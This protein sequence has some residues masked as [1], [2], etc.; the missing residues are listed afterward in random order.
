[1]LP[2]SCRQL[3]EL[4]ALVSTGGAS[5]CVLLFET[6]GEQMH[7]QALHQ[8]CVDGWHHAQLRCVAPVDPV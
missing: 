1:M 4:W 3:A 5:R 6:A 2:P 7:T 8:R